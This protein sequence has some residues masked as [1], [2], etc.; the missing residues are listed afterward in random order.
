MIDIFGRTY[1]VIPF[2]KLYQMYKRRRKIK[3]DILYTLVVMIM[4]LFFMYLLLF[5][6]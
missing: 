4:A 3:E 5:A 2:S 1:K 6:A